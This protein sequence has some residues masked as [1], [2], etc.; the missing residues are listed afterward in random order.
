MEYQRLHFRDTRGRRRN[1]RLY[2]KASHMELG[3]VKQSLTLVALTL[4][5]LSVLLPVWADSG[6]SSSE[7]P[8]VVDYSSYVTLVRNQ[9]GAGGC[10]SMTS[11]A[12]LDLLKEKEYPYAPDASY[13]FAEYVYN[14]R[15][16][17]QLEV[18]KQY[19]CCSEASLL[20]NYDPENPTVPSEKEFKEA[21]LH[22]IE[23]YSDPINEVRVDD[24]RRCLY[25]HGPIFAS[26][27]LPGSKPHGHV[28]AIIGYNDGTE[29]FTV[30]N[31]WGDRWRDNGMLRMPYRSITNP[32][33]NQDTPRVD[34]YRWVNNKASS[35]L[36]PYTGRVRI[37]HESARNHLTIRVG[38]RDRLPAVVWDRPN[39]TR[40]P[41]NSRNLLFDF[42]LPAYAAE[43]W[44]PNKDHPW[45]VEIVDDGEEREAVRPIGVVEEVILVERR[46][47]REPVLYRLTTKKVPFQKGDTVTFWIGRK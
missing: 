21:P 47:G 27:D 8:K 12:I 25:E 36:A 16:I 5:V 22:K 4:A 15:K 20:T 30:I 46:L 13:R 9:G 45:Y 43:C 10:G 38:A 11:L 2:G 23:S 28:F 29:Q 31:S 41:D 26:G 39:R 19:G 24:L 42:P 44:P 32:P 1:M 3:K 18:L 14:D 6:Q 17:N 7:L 37:R 40:I 33:P 35:E 34:W